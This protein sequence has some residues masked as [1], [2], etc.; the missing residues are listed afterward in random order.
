MGPFG[1]GNPAP[2][3][4]S[5]ELHFASAPRRIGQQGQHLSMQFTEA[6]RSL[7]AVAWRMGPMEEPLRRAGSCGAAF[8]CHVSNFRREP[9]VELQIKD[10]WVG[11]YGAE[12]SG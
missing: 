1:A 8:T 4:A 11:K 7:R 9:E 6:G 3:L 12:A 10:M 5:K 2:V